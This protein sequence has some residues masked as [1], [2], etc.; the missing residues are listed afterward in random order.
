MLKISLLGLLVG[1]ILSIAVS[2]VSAKIVQRIVGGL[3]APPGRFLHQVSLQ[4]L[5]GDCSFHVCGGSIIDD[6]HIVTAAHCLTNEVTHDFNHK[7][8]TVVAGT[9]NLRN[10]TS[11]IYRDVQ[12][13]YIPASYKLNAPFHDIAILR[14][15]QPL[16]LNDEHQS[17]QRIRAVKLPA[18]NQ[19]L[20]GYT[21]TQYASASG[22]GVFQER[23]NTYTRQKEQSL[24][25]PT[26]KYTFGRINVVRND[27]LPTQICVTAL[28]QRRPGEDG[29]ICQGDSGGPLTDESTNTLIGITSRTLKRGCGEMSWFTRVSS[30]VNFI[31][32]V[33]QI[34]WRGGLVNPKYI[35]L[36]IQNFD[37]AH[38]MQ[39][40]PHCS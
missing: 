31:N 3:E 8:I 7:Q 16:P 36:H 33:V 9:Q 1:L 40:I 18:V 14:L 32:K 38:I 5:N 11:G 35:S 39:K 19:Y 37:H 26:L 17:N 23:W 2:D 25:S 24:T 34:S 20:P 4:I 22:F 15:K 21:N 13:T 27:C 12:Y 30:F 28:D 6:L 10:K 29:G